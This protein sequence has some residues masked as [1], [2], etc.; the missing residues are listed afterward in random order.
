[1]KGENMK[2]LLCFIVCIGIAVT[3]ANAED[4][5]K[6]PWSEF[7][8]IYRENIEREIRDS[9]PKPQKIKPEP[10]I[11]AIDRAD[12]ELVVGGENAGGRARISGRAISGKPESIPIFDDSVALS[13]IGEISGGVLLP[14]SDEQKGMILFL[15][16]KNAEF[17]L[18]V[19]F[20][21]PTRE[22]SRSRF[23]SF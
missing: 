12:F 22:D 3:G 13:D 19:S 18:V 21:V 17:N 20:L 14:A 15:P 10:F 16:D 7:K 2:G 6:V 4:L 9:L 8:T 1:M 23:V 11:Y 5:V